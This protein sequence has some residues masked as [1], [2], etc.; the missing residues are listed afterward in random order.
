MLHR[1]RI[2][3]KLRLTPVVFTVPLG[4]LR[5]GSLEPLGNL[6]FRHKE[7]L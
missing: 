2:R 3:R 5:D 6:A 7:E 1:E 4:T